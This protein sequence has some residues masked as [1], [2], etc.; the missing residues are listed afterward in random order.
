MKNILLVGVDQM[1]SD[2]IGPNKVVPSSTPHLDDLVLSGASFN[3]AYTACPLCTPSRASML[4]GDY[5]F[6]HGMGTNCD[7]YHALATE[8]PDPDRLL[9]RQLLA[10]GYRCG[11]VGKWHVGKELGPADYGFEGENLS[12]YGNVA[13]SEGFRRY[14]D[15]SGLAYQVE[16]TLYF[17]PDQQ[18]MAGGRW[19]GP[20]ES[21]PAHYLTNQTIGMLDEF[22]S[23]GSP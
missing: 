16:P 9:H 7:M 17:N 13:K 14:L 4:T 18:T 23:R 19:K 11:L 15:E 2:V 12:G 10:S 8:L 20:V 6:T 3:R 21:T 5:A 22:A 1:R